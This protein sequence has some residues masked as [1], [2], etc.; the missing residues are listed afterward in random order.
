MAS[1]KTK[2]SGK[3]K[4]WIVRYDG[5]RDPQTLK[6]KQLQK[7]FKSSKEADQFV[8]LITLQ[9]MNQFGSLQI[10]NGTKSEDEP[11][12]VPFH[13]YAKNWFEVEYFQKVRPNTFK[14]RRFYLEKQIIPFFGDKAFSLITVKDIKEFYAQ[15]KRNGYEQKTISS[16]HKFLSSL[17]NSAVENGDLGE[18]PMNAMKKKPK[19][20]TRIANPWNYTEVVQFLEVAEKEDKDLMYD[21]TLSTGLRQGEVLA[22]PWFNIDLE[23][24]TVTVTRSVSFGENGEP[25]LIPKAQDSYRTISFSSHLI[26]KLKKHKE[27]QDQMKKRFGEHYQH[28]LDLVF[29]VNHGGFQNPSN[30]RRQLYNLMKKAKVRRITFHDLRH[31]HASLLIRSGAQPKLIQTRLGHKVIETTFKYYGHLWP[32]ADQE[33]IVNLEKELKKHRKPKDDPNQM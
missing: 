7:S 24:C 26:D 16:I 27:K 13:V 29:P 22:L 5:E 1:I 30:V 8:A 15:L 12:E 32:N 20:P 3:N 14:S 25:E 21:F 31:T 4:R 23:H 18:S 2:G 33:A 9:G 10:A 19:D 6:R 17:F 11:V 28:E